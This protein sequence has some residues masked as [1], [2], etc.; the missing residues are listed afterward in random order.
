[1]AHKFILY[2]LC[3]LHIFLFSCQ[4]KKDGEEYFLQQQEILENSPES[5]LSQTDTTTLTAPITNKEK[6]ISYLINTLALYYTNT[7]VEPDQQKLSECCSIFEKT[8]FQQPLLESLYLMAVTTPDRNKQIAYI[9]KALKI[10]TEED[11]K[12]WLFYIYYHLGEVYL[13]NYDFLEFVRCKAQA[14]RYVEELDFNN[15]SL[16]SKILVGKNYL[17]NNNLDKALTIF[18]NLDVKETN[19]LY[20]DVK[21]LSGICLYKQQQ[22]QQSIVKLE[23]SISHD[24]SNLNR[25]IASTYLTDCYNKLGNNTMS[26]HYRQQALA[27]DTICNLPHTQI[28]FYKTCIEYAENNGLGE[29]QA[30]YMEKL[31][32]IYENIINELNQ[33]TLDED[34]LKYSQTQEKQQY[35]RNISIYQSALFILVILLFAAVAY[36]LN[37]KKRQAYDLFA[38]Q[39]QIKELEILQQGK[40]E[41][42]R[43]ILENFDIGKKI[44][45]LKHTQKSRYEKLANE[46]SKLDIM[47]NNELLNMHWKS[48]YEHINI[49]FDNFYTKLTTKFPQLN[50]KETQLCCMLIAGFK[51]DEIAAIWLQS[52]FSVH[53]TKTSVRKKLGTE[54]GEDIAEF[55]IKKFGLQ[56]Q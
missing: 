43:L 30:L 38:L 24:T 4:N 19:R 40:D 28:I 48:F 29:E 23:E 37:K 39:E 56:G 3:F 31:L 21:R 13:Q 2:I 25:F 51:T 45:I 7:N 54:Q 42:K 16:R 11:D 27:L 32:N 47:K 10:A 50:E 34:I 1:M 6:A 5:I 52:V 22:W 44:A 26:Q 41:T 49:T 12:E 8:G 9:E 33:G 55:L 15:L 35:L 14:N 20:A 17:H 53:K 46:F 18:E 36:H